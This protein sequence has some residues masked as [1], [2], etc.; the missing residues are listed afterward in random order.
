MSP[1]AR[2]APGAMV[3][4]T[5]LLNLG[6]IGVGSETCLPNLGLIGVRPKEG[7]LGTILGPLEA[8]LGPLGAI[9]G[10]LGIIL[11]Q[12]LGLLVPLGLF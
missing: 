9:L 2:G 6:S 12:F 4:E 7:T 5:C 3:G 11:V 1:R 8:I 10:P